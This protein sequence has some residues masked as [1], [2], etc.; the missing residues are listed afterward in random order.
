MEVKERTT[1]PKGQT[2]V[3]GAVPGLFTTNEAIIIYDASNKIWAATLDFKEGS[4]D[5][6]VHFFTNDASSKGKIHPD[7]ES[8]REGF[9]S[10]KM[11]W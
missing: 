11:V 1:N 8:W 4:D 7:I 2:V 6:F 5:P 3:T 10:Y 9:K